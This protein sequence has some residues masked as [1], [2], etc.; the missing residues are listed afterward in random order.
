MNRLDRL[1]AV[2]LS[3]CLLLGACS[4]DEPDSLQ[5]LDEIVQSAERTLCPIVDPADVDAAIAGRIDDELIEAARLIEAVSSTAS[6]GTQIVA[7]DF[8]VGPDGDERRVLSIS[9]ISTPVEELARRRNKPSP[10]EL[11]GE[12]TDRGRL[13]IGQT[14]GEL[15]GADVHLSVLIGATGEAFD[16][17]VADPG[18]IFN[19]LL[20]AVDR[21]QP[22]LIAKP[23]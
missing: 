12:I 14:A 13:I 4:S 8:G 19:D 9:A 11:G 10:E 7:C 20:D 15:I 3:A 17:P 1:A 16:N 18:P 21:K 23:G 5:I 6:D 22:G 2:T